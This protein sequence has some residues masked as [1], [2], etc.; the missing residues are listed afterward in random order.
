[1]SLYCPGNARSE[2]QRAEM[3]RLESQQVCV[4]CPGQVNGQDVYLHSTDHWSVRP[5]Q[6]PYDGAQLHVLLVPDVHVGKLLEL[7]LA[8]QDDMWTV[9]GWVVGEYDL[10]HWT[11]AARNGPC[12]ATGGTIEHL[13]LH[14][15]V[16]DP[17]GPPV[18]FTIGGN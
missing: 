6:Y 2:L 7:P 3:V 14:L 15:I 9:L 10:S 17:T 1:M 18:E 8:A 5:N 16:N 12:D 13:H 4:F 11:L